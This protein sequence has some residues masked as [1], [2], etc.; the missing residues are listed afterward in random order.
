MKKQSAI[1]DCQHNITRAQMVTR[2]GCNFNRIAGPKS[3][4]HTF[5][6]HA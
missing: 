4:Q 5:A 3:G 1:A 2:A 6:M